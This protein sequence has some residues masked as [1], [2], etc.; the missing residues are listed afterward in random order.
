MAKITKE[1]RN[2]VLAMALGDGTLSVNGYL[3]IRHSV[4]QLEYLQWKHDTLKNYGVKV[5]DIYPVNNNG[6]GGYEFR[7]KSYDFIKVLRKQLYP[8]GK[9]DISKKSIYNKIGIIGLSI[10]YMDDGSISTQK[11]KNGK[12]HRSILTISTCIDKESNQKIIDSISGLYDINFG[13][14]KMKKSYALVI[15]TREARKFIDLVSPYVGQV[16][17]MQYKLNVKQ[18]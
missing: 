17:C 3:A 8:G 4:D 7:T 18:P 15:S 5:C 13:Q 2:L 14:R 1:S 10:W 16:S 12:V 9:K 11:N 6:Y